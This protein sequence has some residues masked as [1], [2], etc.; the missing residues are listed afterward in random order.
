MEAWSA[1][2]PEPF[3]GFFE[4]RNLSF[5]KLKIFSMGSFFEHLKFSDSVM[6]LACLQLKRRFDLPQL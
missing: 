4:K 5:S 6:L 3:N 1:W 2:V